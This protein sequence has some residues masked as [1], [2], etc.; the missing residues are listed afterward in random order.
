M[1]HL[2]GRRDWDVELAFAYAHRAIMRVVR[3]ISKDNPTTEDSELYK[4]AATGLSNL[5]DEIVFN[6]KNVTE[7]ARGIL[8]KYC[9]KQE[10]AIA[11]RISKQLSASG[12]HFQTP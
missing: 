10:L 4:L 6:P 2:T 11:Q 1:E 7:M 9:N 5:R 3:Q 12:A 8:S